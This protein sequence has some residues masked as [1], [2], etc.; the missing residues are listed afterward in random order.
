MKYIVIW[1]FTSDQ[2]DHRSTECI[3]MYFDAVASMNVGGWEHVRNRD[4]RQPQLTNMMMAM[5]MA[6]M[7]S[8]ENDDD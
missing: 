3:K 2:N 7:K 4:S 1:H 8:D 6:M 5:I